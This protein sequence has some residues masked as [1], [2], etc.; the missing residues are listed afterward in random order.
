MNAQRS[1]TLAAVAGL[2]FV[3]PAA[4]Q[5]QEIAPDVQ[6]LSVTPKRFKALATGSEVVTKG[7]GRVTF[8]LDTGSFIDFRVS[9]LKP[10]KRTAAGCVAGKA[11][12]KAK[13]CTRVVPIPGAFIFVGIPGDNELRLSGR[14]KGKSLTPGAY[15]LAA[16]AHGQAARSSYATFRIA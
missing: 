6:K 2:L 15:R 7:G 8:T 13:R 14:L 5:I 4:A 11:K 3:A 12:T 10:G 16:K 1:I 9:A